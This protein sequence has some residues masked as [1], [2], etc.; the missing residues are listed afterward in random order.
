LNVQWISPDAWHP[1]SAD[2]YCNFLCWAIPEEM[3][4]R[5][6]AEVEIQIKG[7]DDALSGPERERLIG[8]LTARRYR[9][10]AESLVELAALQGLTIGRRMNASP[11]AIL[12][13][14]IVSSR[15]EVA[16]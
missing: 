8:Q 6:C 11:Q 10:E 13:V 16:A 15:Q 2:D 3:T 1:G 7:G 5:L 4:E 12:S 9:L 14:R